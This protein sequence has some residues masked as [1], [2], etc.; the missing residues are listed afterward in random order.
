MKKVDRFK[1]YMKNSE[2]LFSCP[3]C[4]ASMVVDDNHIVC[5]QNHSFDIAKKG[6]INMMTQ[7]VHTKYDKDLFEARYQFIQHG[8][9]KPL[10]DKISELIGQRQSVIDLGCGEG[11][12]LAK[13]TELVNHDMIRAGL[14]I[15]KEG[16]MTASKYHLDAIWCVGD[17]AQVPFKDSSFDV[18]LNILSPANYGEFKRLL[19]DD[20]FVIKVFPNSGY[21]KEL[22]EAFY[23]NEEY[24]NE[25]TKKRFKESLCDIQEERLTYQAP[26]S[27]ELVPF[28]LKM[29]PLTWNL[30]E[31][32][33]LELK[34]VTVDVD[35]LVGRGG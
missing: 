32:V 4:A 11:S 24:S 5:K 19:S 16:V 3:I 8:V 12:H 31:R 28:L 33:D 23:N 21:L 35:I 9:Y 6:Y 30:N 14:D 25:E 26:I 1:S 18:V 15:A 13:I 2:Q 29:T 22:R 34:E 10:H 17:L 7:P 27:A 20:G